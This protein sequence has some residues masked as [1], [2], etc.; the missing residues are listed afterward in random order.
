MLPLAQLSTPPVLAAPGVVG[1]LGTAS[2]TT[3]G[4]SLSISGVTASAGNSV[5]VS[6][7]MQARSGTVSC[8][9]GLN[10]YTVDADVFN[11]GNVRTV[12]CSTHNISGLSGGTITI[13]HPSASL[14]AASAHEFSGLSPSS[15]R[16]QLGTATGSGA[17]PSAGPTSATT[18]AD[19]LV[20]SA[21]GVLGAS[22]PTFSAGTGFTA[23]AAASAA[24]GGLTPSTGAASTSR[25]ANSTNGTS[26]TLSD[27][28]SGVGRLLVVSITVAGDVQSSL[29]APTGWTPML[30]GYN[31]SI[32]Q[33]TYFRVVAS[34]DPGSFAWTWSGTRDASGGLFSFA[35]N[36]FA[37]SPVQVAG[38]AN[39]S[40]T[41]SHSAPSVTTTVSDTHLL[42]AYGLDQNTSLIRDDPSMSAAYLITSGG[43]TSL[44][45]HGLQAAV[46][47]TGARTATSGVAA[48]GIG[49]TFA[50][51]PAAVS[52]FPQYRL[53]STAG[54]QSADGTLG[55]S[56]PWAGALATYKRDVTGWDTYQAGC[57]TPDTTFD[58]QSNRV[59]CA[60]GNVNATSG[61]YRV[62]FYDG[63]NIGQLVDANGSPSGGV[64]TSGDHDLASQCG[65]CA[66]GT[67]HVVVYANSATPEP[68]YIGA[69][70]EIRADRAF[71]V[72]AAALPDLPTPLAGL[73]AA[74]G[75]G[76]VY[77]LLRR[78]SSGSA[79]GHEPTS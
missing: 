79:D 75:A 37:G 12:I 29:S 40:S 8:S 69:A 41:T 7:A 63:A 60:R 30:T 43:T 23:L 61:S 57:T 5:V 44:L 27:P 13:S 36:F 33:G 16:D 72:T 52:L 53:V 49:Q 76:L 34:G 55:S 68:T 11:S 32:T 51:N 19:E 26:L 1:S 14:R 3:V 24:A 21:F 46:G 77:L 25:D 31:G 45:T 47:A 74:G 58:N 70:A 71:T 78:Q 73:L 20:V 64:L 66:P 35:G 9:D 22:T 10:S 2:A 15:T 62:V 28:D 18:Q 38:Q 4:T 65:P 59:V 54:I 56:L 6:F 17:S 48:N 42:A 39:S 67:W 50:I